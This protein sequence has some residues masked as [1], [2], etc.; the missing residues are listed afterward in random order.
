MTFAYATSPATNPVTRLGALALG[1][2]IEAACAERDPRNRVIRLLA[3][4]PDAPMAQAILAMSAELAE[5]DVVLGAAFARLPHSAEED[6]GLSALARA[7]GAAR[8]AN[9]VRHAR[10]ASADRLSET[11]V[12]GERTAW[13]GG[14][15]G[16]EV[17]PAVAE[18]ELLDL[19]ARPNTAKIAQM[20]FG[21]VWTRSLR[22]E[23]RY[24]AGVA[25]SVL[26]ETAGARVAAEPRVSL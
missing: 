19:R 18:L 14:L 10:F 20:S 25:E 15:M 7:F 9:F 3:T 17:S 12:V 16:A 4:A 2:A 26:A 23:A 8:A 1:A 11:C 21:A 6:P 5:H 13:V 24:F 22:L